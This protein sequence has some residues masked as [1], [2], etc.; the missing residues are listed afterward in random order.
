VMGPIVLV[1]GSGVLGLTVIENAELDHSTPS[2]SGL[3]RTGERCGSPAASLRAV[4]V[5]PMVRSSLFYAIMLEL[6]EVETVKH[7]Q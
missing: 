3:A 6:S 4:R 1:E 7:R 5:Q 2:Y